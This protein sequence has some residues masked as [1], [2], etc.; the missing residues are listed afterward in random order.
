[1]H[2]LAA[3]GRH[4][5]ESDPAVEHALEQVRLLARGVELRLAVAA[6]D[7]VELDAAGPH[8]A[9][10]ARHELAVA[11]VEA[12]GDP[13]DRREL[14]D[15]RPQVGVQALPVLVRLPRALPLWYRAS[16]ASTSISSAEKPVRS[17]CVIR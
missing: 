5:A 6:R 1:M 10:D 11:A 15:D 14:F 3:A 13:Q 7:R 8:A 9:G 4:G 16:D 2:G 17:P 12:V